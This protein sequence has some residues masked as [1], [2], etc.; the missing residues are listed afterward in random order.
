MVVLAGTVNLGAQM[1]AA[2]EAG[3]DA[4]ISPGIT[5]SLLKMAKQLGIPYL[6]GVGTA[7]EVLLAME[8]GLRECKLFPAT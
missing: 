8:Y 5:E 1:I 6:P 4:I 2:V 3:V 7:S